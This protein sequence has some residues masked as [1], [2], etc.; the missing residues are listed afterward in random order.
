MLR[1][2]SIIDENQYEMKIKNLN[3]KNVDMIEKLENP[4]KVMN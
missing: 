4:L 1:K 3:L 2:P